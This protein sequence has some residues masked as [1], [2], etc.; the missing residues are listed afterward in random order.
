VLENDRYRL[1]FDP[2]S[3]CI[4]SLR[5]KINQLEAFS[6]SAA[7][8]VV[9]DDPSDTWSHDVF[10]FDKVIGVF[11]AKS[12]KMIEHGPVRSTIRV[13]SAVLAEGTEREPQPGRASC[14]V[15]D[16]ERSEPQ[17]FSVRSTSLLTRE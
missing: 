5:D 14:V 1:E 11:A 2:A 16:N 13:T 7:N 4:I 9:I 17:G 12:V 6:G 8:P 15:Y 3:G 10:A